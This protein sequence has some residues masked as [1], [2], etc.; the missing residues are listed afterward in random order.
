MGLLL[1]LALCI[2][3]LCCGAMSPPQ[4]ALNPSALLSR[5]CN[6]SD[7][8]AV[9]G[10]ALRD[11]NKDRKD[12]YVLRLNRVNDAQEYR[13][14]YGQCKAIFYM[15]NP[16]R[17]LYLAAYNC[18]L[19]PVSKKKIYMTCPDCPSSIPT[20]SSNHQVLE[21]ATESLAKYNNENTSKQ[22]SLFKVTRASSQ[23]VVGPSYFVEYLIKESPC[24]KSQASSC[25]LQSSDS[26]PVGLCKG[27][28]TRTHWEKFVSVTCDFFESQAPATGSEN[29]AV[30]QKPTNLPK[31][32]E[33]QQKNT[34][35]TDSPSKAGPRGSVQYLPDL[36]DKNS[37]E[38]GPQ[39]AFPVHLDL[40]TNPQGETLDISFLFLEPME[41]KLVVLP[42]PKEK[43]RTAECPG[44]AQ[45]AS[46]LVLPP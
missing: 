31:V 40:T 19:R 44:P 24:T 39:E 7:V 34:P 1:P 13:R 42:F 37:Q 17:V 41:E 8:L 35:P 22:Y 15:N 46:P 5:G 33:S 26:V 45:N 4:L 30:N 27:S 10:F 23:W 2:L 38:K 21:A 43:A 16:S 28:L 6:D 25:S 9:A 3:V 12:G 14:V 11:I 32:E 36:D 18:T 29:S 20:D